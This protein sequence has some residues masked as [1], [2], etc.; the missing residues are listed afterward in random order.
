MVSRLWGIG[1]F[2]SAA[3]FGTGCASVSIRVDRSSYAAGDSGHAQITN[4][5]VRTAYGNFCASYTLERRRGS[6]WIPI[7]G[8]DRRCTKQLD[9]YGPGS[10]RAAV[11]HIPRDTPSGTYRLVTRVEGGASDEQVASNEFVVVGPARMQ[12]ACEVVP[13]PRSDSRE[14]YKGHVIVADECAKPPAL[15]I[16]GRSV[17]VRREAPVDGSGP[18][19]SSPIL[20]Y[21]THPTLIALARAIIDTG[22][23]RAQ[24]R[25][26]RQGDE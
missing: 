21:S 2:V 17:S 18:R 14:T 26:S 20:S 5:G 6:T 11:F 10:E 16:D 22:L 4:E 7:E 3:L 19:F 23:L 15:E 12:E 1:A 13:H 9:G 8:E 25:D 24:R